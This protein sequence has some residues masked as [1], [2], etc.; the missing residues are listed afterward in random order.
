[1]FTSIITRNTFSS[2]SLP[3][4]NM[5]V[6][7]QHNGVVVLFAGGVYLLQWY[8]QQQQQQSKMV[9]SVVTVSPLFSLPRSVFLSPD[10]AFTKM[11]LSSVLPV[12]PKFLPQAPATSSAL[13][14]CKKNSATVCTVPSATVDMACQILARVAMTM[15]QAAVNQELRATVATRL[16][17]KTALHAAQQE[18]Y[19]KIQDAYKKKHEVSKDDKKALKD[20]TGEGFA[21]MNS[22]FACWQCRQ[23]T[24]NTC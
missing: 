9:D 23:E 20:Y 11:D 12:A 4:V 5:V 21:E 7:K 6:A 15:L 14:A 22:A 2:S 8:K 19:Q 17:Q 13:V 3:L 24:P 1:M 18:C 16:E 10:F